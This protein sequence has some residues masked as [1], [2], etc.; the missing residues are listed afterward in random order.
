MNLRLKHVLLAGT[1]CFIIVAS[2]F[3][4]S[5]PVENKES[6]AAVSFGYPMS[7]LSQDMSLA[8]GFSFFPNYFKL[9]FDFKKYPLSGFSFLAFITDFLI[10]FGSIEA[11]VF[12]L[13]K[14]KALLID[15]KIWPYSRVD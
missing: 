7:F 6:L 15:R 1:S 2:L 9:S 3:I 12:L 8:D 4:L 5:T 11:I 14:G 13:E 10:I